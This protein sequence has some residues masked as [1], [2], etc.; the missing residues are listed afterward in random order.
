[1]ATIVDGGAIMREIREEVRQ[2]IAELVERSRVTPRVAIVEFDANPETTVYTRQLQ[3]AFSAVGIETTVEQIP[4]DA[5]L[6]DARGTLRRLSADATVHGIQVQMP[7][8]KHISL[9][10]LTQAL[11]PA[12]DLDGIHPYNAGL[13]AQGRPGIVP[14]TPL[15]GIEILDR[16]GIQIA[17]ARAVV[18]GRS[19]SVGRPAAALLVQRDAT[20]TVCHTK[21]RDMTSV[22][23]Q[24][25]ILMVAAGRA[26]LVGPE[27]VR[28]GA[29]VIDFGINAV[30]GKL[31]GDVDAA[32]AEIAGLFTPVPG[33][34]GPVTNAMMLRNALALYGQV[35]EES[36]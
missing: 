24:A 8:P 25:E 30:D 22:T 19:V 5:P 12:K 7:L 2:K 16:H 9:P 21:T 20:V 18:V 34:T 32:A 17:G 26:A 13:L 11:D 10:D 33:G 6:D 29:A 36:R 15:A 1:M 27:M 4:E 3:R 23:S 31:I 28:P 14:A 35:V